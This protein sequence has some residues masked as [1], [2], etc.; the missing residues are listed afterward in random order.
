MNAFFGIFGWPYMTNYYGYHFSIK[1]M[2]TFAMSSP[3]KDNILNVKL[4]GN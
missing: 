4:L 3:P 1:K 2:L